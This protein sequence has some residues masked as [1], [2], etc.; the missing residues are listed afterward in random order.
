[1]KPNVYFQNGST[2]IEPTFGTLIC[3]ALVTSKIYPQDPKKEGL[4]ALFGLYR[5]AKLFVYKSE[6]ITSIG[7]HFI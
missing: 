2:D 4:D 5:L 1:M 7:G 3:R 6:K